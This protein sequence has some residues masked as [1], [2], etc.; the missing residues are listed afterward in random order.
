MHLKF[1]FRNRYGLEI[2]GLANFAHPHQ[3]EGN[4]EDTWDATFSRAY[5][6]TPGQVVAKFES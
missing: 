1:R 3:G 4:T 2:E 5:M 6:T